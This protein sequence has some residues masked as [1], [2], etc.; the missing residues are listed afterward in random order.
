MSVLPRIDC[1]LMVVGSGVST[2]TEVEESMNRL[3]K[4]NM[5]GVILNKDESPTQN[6]YY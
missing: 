1:V 6:A 4:A 2:Q 3:S 5:L